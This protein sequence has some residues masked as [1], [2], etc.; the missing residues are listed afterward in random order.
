MSYLGYQSIT[1]PNIIVGTGKE[2]I[3]DIQMEE[4]FVNMKEVEITATE[5]RGEALNEM[6]IISSRA[7][8]VEETERYA[9]SRGDPARM[10]S[11]FA[12]VGGADDSRNDIVVR[13]NSPMGVL[14]RFEG[15]D[16]PNPN[17]FA[18]SGTQGGPTSI[19]NNKYLGNSDFFTGAFP[20]EFGNSL[21]GVFDLKMRAGNNEKHEFTYQFGILGTEIM[22]EGPISKSKRSSYLV[23][24]RYSTL[25]LF[26]TLGIDVGTSAALVYQDAAFKFNFPLKSGGNFSVF[27]IGGM[28]DIDIVISEQKPED[29]E[30]YGVQDRDQYFGTKMGVVGATFTKSLSKSAYFK[31]TIAQTYENQHSFHQLLYYS[32]NAT[33]D[34]TFEYILDSEGLYQTDSLVDLQ[35][36][37]FNIGKTT[38]ALFVN[39]KFNSKH[40]VKIGT[41]FD[42]F[43]INFQDSLYGTNSSYKW[44]KRWDNREIA[45]LLQPYIQW[46]WKI[47]E[48]LTLNAGL[49]NQ[50]FT[51]NNTYSLA[52]PRAG[53]RWDIDEKQNLSIGIGRHSQIHPLYIYTYQIPDGNGGFVQHNRDIGMSKTN[54]IILGYNRFVGKSLR[55]K[56]ETYYQQLSNVPVE[57]KTSSFSLL[58]QGVGFQRFFPDSLQN[59]GWGQNYGAELT[60]EKFFS[61]Q[62]F[63]MITAAYY[64]SF[65]RGSDGII[66]DTDFNG[67][68]IANF[69]GAKEFTVRKNNAFTVGTKITF[70]GNKRY[71]PV[72]VAA[73]EANAEIIYVDVTRNS[74]QFDPYFR[75]DLKLNYKINRKRVS[76]EISFDLVNVTDNK[77]ILKLSY[78]PNLENPTEDPI[79][80]EYQLGFLPIFYYRIDF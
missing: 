63:F 25:T 35:K 29:R 17:H 44:V 4:S 15:I 9:G 28:S 39:K 6:A 5:E 23:N 57:V 49:H 51:L 10:A 78:A 65:Y 30:I 13:G 73:S 33:S 55:L 31:T 34:S 41:N 26:N 38:G 12:G 16:I 50:Y 22:A 21:S 37:K 45:S 70:A 60:L 27:G 46:K 3:L 20:A 24:Y 62:Y 40:V 79:R 61:R 56:A 59:T 32:Q 75:A 77:N 67:N 48:K 47:S 74:K 52:E 11:N 64:E 54:H 76:H 8:S 42:V 80:E 68:Y 72:D 53:L 1:L 69:L 66:R 2:V 43:Y 71:G 58:N 36:F 18:V 14:W 7:F 19:I